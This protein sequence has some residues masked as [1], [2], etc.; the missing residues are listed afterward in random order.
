MTTRFAISLGAILLAIIV[1]MQGVYIVPETHRAVLLRFGG[2]VESDIGAGLHFKIPFVDVARKF[3]I[4]VLVMDLPT[5]SYLTGEQKP[6][7]VDSYATWRIVNVGQFYRSTAGDENNAVR[8]LES[9]IDN[10]LRD[11]FGRRTMHEVVAGER[12]ELME[13]LTKS[14]D[15]IARTEFG[16]EINDIRVRAIELPTR[17]SDSVYERMESERLKIAQQHRSQGEEQ[18]EAVRAA[19]DAERTV[20]DANAYKE[21]EQ[22]RGEGDS[23]ASRIYADAFSKNPEF[24]SFYRSMGAYEQTFSSKGDLLI[25]Q[26]DSEFLRYLKQPR[27]ASQGN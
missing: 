4:R 18:A 22:I 5:K 26:P 7:D 8:L 2:M 27:G 13:E 20:I 3:D 23:V 9:R 11:Q 19:A 21:A 10:G 14:L 1:V 25:L 16:I 24:Y 6:L 15:Q 12:E 17:V